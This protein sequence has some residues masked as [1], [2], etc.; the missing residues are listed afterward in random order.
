MIG[1]NLQFEVVKL[2]LSSWKVSGSIREALEVNWGYPAAEDLFEEKG[3]VRQQNFHLIWWEGLG[4]VMA[5]YPKM[6]HAWLTKHVSEFCGNNV[7]LY[8][9][10]QGVHSPKCESCGTYDE[11]TTHIRRCRDLGRDQMFRVLVAEL[12]EWLATTLGELMVSSMVESYLLSRGEV[13]MVSCLHGNCNDL[14]HVAECS[15][16]LGWDSL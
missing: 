13:T 15:D 8:Y 11:Y 3:I 1:G 10:S 7:Q 12:R 6:Y 4:T 16:R 2:S 5:R 14:R 9:W